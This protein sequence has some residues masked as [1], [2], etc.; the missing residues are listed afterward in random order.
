MVKLIVLVK[1]RPGMSVE[2]FHRYWREVHGPLAMTTPSWNR[3][4]RR[5]VQSH[6]THDAYERGAAPYDGLVEAWFDDQAAIDAFLAQEDYRATISE[7]EAKL[8]DREA[9]VFFTVDEVEMMS[10]I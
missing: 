4:V 3:Y 2:E 8:F 1:R 5:Y 7:H 9:M 6:T 10:Q